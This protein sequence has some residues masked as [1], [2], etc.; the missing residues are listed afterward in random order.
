MLMGLFTDVGTM[1]SLLIIFGMWATYS[2]TGSIVFLVLGTPWE[3][4]D[5]WQ[6]VLAREVLRLF[7]GFLAGMLIVHM[8]IVLV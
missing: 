4:R 7:L 1:D 2:I 5:E 6:Y 3:F 8:S